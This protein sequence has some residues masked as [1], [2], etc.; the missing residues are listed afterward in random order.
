MRKIVKRN[1]NKTN[2]S[3]HGKKKRKTF[4][5]SCRRDSPFCCGGFRWNCSELLWIEGDLRAVI[6][7]QSWTLSHMSCLFLFYR[8]TLRS[9]S[10]VVLHQWRP[11]S[12]QPLGPEIV[13]ERRRVV[14]CEGWKTDK[15]A[16]KKKNHHEVNPLPDGCRN[17]FQSFCDPE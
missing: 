1:Q 4:S 10:S 16:K 9:S 13:K 11:V 2:L 7:P 6:A 8:P 17:Q 15:R 14:S 5:W 12:L 3:Q